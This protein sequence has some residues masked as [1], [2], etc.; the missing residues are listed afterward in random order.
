MA[1][2]HTRVQLLPDLHQQT[3]F[4]GWKL[5]DGHT[6]HT[7]DLDTLLPYRLGYSRR[8]KSFDPDVREIR[9]GN[10]IIK[11]TR[12]AAL[13]EDKEGH[14]Y[15]LFPSVREAIVERAIRKLAVQQNAE[16][17]LICDR[18]GREP[19]EIIRVTFTLS[20]LRR[21]LT[22]VHHGYNL[23]E[24][25]EALEVLSGSLFTVTSESNK[26]LHGS[27]GALFEK[28][29]FSYGSNDNSGDRSFVQLDYHE[30]ATHSIRALTYFP[31]NYDRLMA[32]KSP[33]AAWLVTKM[34]NRYRQAETPRVPSM[35]Q[36]ATNNVKPEGYHIAL[37][38]IVRESGLPINDRTRDAI[39]VVRAALLEMTEKKYLYPF[40][41]ILRRK[42][43]ETY[44]DFHVGYTED[45]RYQHGI[46][47]PKIENIIW[48]LYPSHEFASEILAGSIVMNP[49][50][51]KKL[52][53][54][55]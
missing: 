13:L 16:M 18:S 14:G 15:Y 52:A 3:F 32:L 23:S 12:K 46:G 38:T 39:P 54:A 37:S 34:N 33:L 10:D 22:A 28:L 8:A 35:S 29:K 36:M 5:Q 27:K 48:T 21:E 30:L 6:S 42:E 31:I 49:L 25:K 53:A 9:L 7:F 4:E 55:T 40:M 51:K 2:K 26:A 1:R 17:V 19:T 44:K 45:I 24:I 43:G 41:G 50:R 47:R 20:Q 11:V